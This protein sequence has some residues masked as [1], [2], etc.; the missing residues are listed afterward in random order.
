MHIKDIIYGKELHQSLLG[1]QPDDMDDREWALLDRK[2][3][4]DVRL[5]LSKSVGHNVV[6]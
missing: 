3:L 1:E 5:S 2:A 4:A 6:K